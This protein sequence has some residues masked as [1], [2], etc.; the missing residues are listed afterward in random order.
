MNRTASASDW[1]NS[2]PGV[3]ATDQFIALDR[4]LFEDCVSRAI[5][6]TQPATSQEGEA[7]QRGQE[8]MR[9]RA[10]KVCDER[11]KEEQEGYGLNRAAQNYYRARNAVRDLPI[12]AA[13]PT[14]P[15]LSED[16]R[17]C[18]ELLHGMLLSFEGQPTFNGDLFKIVDS[19]LAQVKA[20]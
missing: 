11:G 19:A 18:I 6:A 2:I 9:E 12:L 5:A 17:E 3:K 1:V 8:D 7:Y 10:A 16:L 15:T 14:P 4:R 20:S 13:T